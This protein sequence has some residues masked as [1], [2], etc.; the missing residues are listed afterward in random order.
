MHCRDKFSIFYAASRFFVYNAVIAVAIFARLKHLPA[1][2]A[3][4]TGL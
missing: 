2:A 3:D 1:Y 4:W